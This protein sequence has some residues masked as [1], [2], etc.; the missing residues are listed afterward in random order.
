MTDE[1][2]VLQLTEQLDELLAMVDAI[3][4]QLGEADTPAPVLH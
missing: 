4:L 2:E 3:L 1:E